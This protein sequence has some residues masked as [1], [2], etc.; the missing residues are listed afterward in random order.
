MS[1]QEHYTASKKATNA[2]RT[3]KPIIFVNYYYYY[4][5]HHHFGFGLM[6]ATAMVLLAKNWTKVP[7]Q[8]QTFIFEQDQNQRYFS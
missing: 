8:Y 1:R 7:Q 5:D 2:K 4:S 3:C 6:N